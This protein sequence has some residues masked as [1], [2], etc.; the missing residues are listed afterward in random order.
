MKMRGFLI[1]AAAAY[2]MLALLCLKAPGL[3]PATS[4]LD[5]PLFMGPPILL[6]WGP[7]ALPMFACLTLTLAVLLACGLRFPSARIPAAI[8]AAMVWLFAGWFSVAMSI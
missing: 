2:F 3:L 4:R 8:I 1:A 6:V 5:Y 7:G